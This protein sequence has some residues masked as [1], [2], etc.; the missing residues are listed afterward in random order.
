M[1]LRGLL[2]LLALL[3]G[4]VLSR[5]LAPWA[6]IIPYTIS[7]MLFLTFLKVRPRDLR[8]RRSHLWLLIIQ[9]SLSAIGYWVGVPLGAL[10]AQAVLLLLLTPA[11][12]ASPTIVMLLG[13]DAGYTT[14]YV[15]VSHAMVMLTAPLVLPL[16]GDH[17]TTEAMGFVWQAKQI[18]WSIAPLIIPAIALAW[19]L[20]AVRPN[21]AEKISRVKRLPFGLWLLSL[22]LLIAHTTEF[23]KGYPG[24]SWADVGLLA[25]LSLGACLI[26]FGLGHW[27]APRLEGE[28]HAM[29]HALGQKNT[30]L[31]LWLASLFLS[32]LVCVAIACYILWQNIMITYVLARLKPQ[33]EGRAKT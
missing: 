14:S 4:V 33:T 19:G 8:L 21:L 10:A 12:T 2:P 25:A 9:L 13:G 29:R 31:S 26:Q 7:G 22:L 16:V 1:T 18:F 28:R 15:L 3:W 5:W 32:P 17:D 30:T 6:P 20:L 27:L 11:A 24:W 23:M